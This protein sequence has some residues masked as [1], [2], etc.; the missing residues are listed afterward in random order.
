MSVLSS[1]NVGAGNSAGFIEP[2][3]SLFP[4]TGLSGEIIGQSTAFRQIIEQIEMVAPT[5]ATVLIQG[6]TGTGKELI[7]RELHRRSRRKD[8]PLVAVNCS[9][10]PKDL[11]ESEFFGCT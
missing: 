10:I 11:Y 8:K 1:S 6:E 7:A 9:C 4:S 3:G 2:V 5:D